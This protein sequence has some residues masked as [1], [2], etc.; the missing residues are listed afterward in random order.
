MQYYL[1]MT[2]SCGPWLY[3]YTGGI[4]YHYIRHNPFW[5]SSLLNANLDWHRN[6]QLKPITEEE[7]FLW[8]MSNEN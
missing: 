4:Y 8:I 5:C 7:A 3:K 6:V 2:D 1:D